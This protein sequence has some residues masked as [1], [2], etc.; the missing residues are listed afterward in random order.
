MPSACSVPGGGVCVLAF[1][2]SLGSMMSEQE[3]FVL[4]GGIQSDV[5]PKTFTRTIRNITV[6]Q[7]QLG[8]RP[9]Y[10]LERESK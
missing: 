5:S 10:S 2:C 7:L 1:H 6:C 3:K 8:R 9:S 4:K